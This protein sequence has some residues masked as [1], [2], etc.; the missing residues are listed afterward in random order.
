MVEINVVIL[1][2]AALTLIII[3]VIGAVMLSE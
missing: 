1:V 3:G 2:L